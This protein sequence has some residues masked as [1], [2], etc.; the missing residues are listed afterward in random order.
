MYAGYRGRGKEWAESSLGLSVEVVRRS[1]K[2]TPEEVV[3]AWSTREW[4]KEGRSVVVEE[5]LSH[6]GF[7]VL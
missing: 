4:H 2:P 5:L 1:P 6:Q 7:E 3:L